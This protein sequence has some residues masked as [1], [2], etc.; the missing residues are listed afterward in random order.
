MRFVVLKKGSIFAVIVTIILVSVGTIWA[1]QNNNSYPTVSFTGADNEV[2]TIHMV[3]D[4]IEMISDNGEKHEVYRWD[5]S[6]IFVEKGK[7]LELRMYGVHGKEHPFYIEG[8]DVKGTISKGKE[9]VVS[10]SFDKEGTYR[11]V[12]T[13]HSNHD[14]SG[15][16]VAYIVVD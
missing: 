11:I 5:P 12:C 8:T 7:K 14:Q 9:S 1:L 3:T 13:L 2:Q 10:V 6:T 16:M 15:P 4:E